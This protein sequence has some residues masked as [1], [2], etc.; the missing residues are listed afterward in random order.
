MKN[1]TVVIV[2]LLSAVAVA[3]CLGAVGAGQSIRL[4]KLK[5]NDDDVWNHYSAVDASFDNRGSKEYWVNCR[6]H[7]HVFEAPVSDHIVNQGAPAQSFVDSLA[8]N[9][10]RVLE[11]YPRVMDF[12]DGLNRFITINDNFNTLE[13]VDG[14]GLDGSKALKASYTGFLCFYVV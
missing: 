2:S 11:R 7:E 10:D 14:E 4:N 12:E 8:A 3:L 5:A 13:V 9:D 6:T 1:K